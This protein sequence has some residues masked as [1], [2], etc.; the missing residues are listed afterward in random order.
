MSHLV[1][2]LIGG[3]IFPYIFELLKQNVEKKKEAINYTK[4]LISS[5][6]GVPLGASL[7]IICG[8]F[9]KTDTLKNDYLEAFYWH[10][11]VI[12][13]IVCFFWYL[14]FPYPLKGEVSEPI[15]FWG[16]FRYHFAGYFCLILGYGMSVFWLIP[17]FVFFANVKSLSTFEV[18]VSIVA[19][20]LFFI[21]NCLLWYL[22]LRNFSRK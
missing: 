15:S 1:E 16:R 9:L 13:S 14:N 5:Y 18:V 3:I 7:V 6:T 2:L 11:I 22:I 17:I 19:L 8:N 12:C 20:I 10:Y 21:F 4:L